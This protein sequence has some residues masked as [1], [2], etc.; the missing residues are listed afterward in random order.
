M[1]KLL[2]TTAFLILFCN[3]TA[4]TQQNGTLTGKVTDRVTGEALPGANIYIEGKTIGATTDVEGIYRLMNVPSG[5]YNVIVQFIGYAKYVEAVEISPG[6]IVEINAALSMDALS[7]EEVYVSAQLLG[8]TKAINQQLN[9]DALVNVVSSDKIKELPDVNAAEAIGRLPG[10]SVIRNGGEA[11]R[12]VVRGLSPNLTTISIN[13]VKVPATGANDRGVDLSMVSPDLLSNIEVFKSP[14]ADMDGDAIGGIVNLGIAKAPDRPTAAFRLY[15]GYNSLEEKFGNYK[16]TMDLSKRFFNNKLGILLRANKEQ[17][18]RSSENISVGYNTDDTTQFLVSNLNIVD[19]VSIIRRTGG[20]IQADYQYGTGYIIGQGFYSRRY[21]EVQTRNNN[22]VNGGAVGHDPRHSKSN[23]YTY[24]GMLNG[25]QNL[26]WIEIDW[27]MAQSKTVGDNY[28]DVSL[29]I[30]ERSGVEQTAEPKTPQELLAKRLFNYGSAWIDRYYWEPSINDQLNRTASVDFKIDYNLGSKLGGFI[31]FGGKYRSEE[32]TREIDYQ[33]QNWYYLQPQARA[34]AVEL[35][36]YDMILGG[37]TGNMIMIDNFYTS[38][39]RL[40]IWNN[41]YFIHPKIDMGLL[42]EWH[43]YQQSTLTKQYSQEYLNYSIDEQVTAGYLMAKINWGK[44]LTLIPGVRYEYSDNSYSGIISSLDNSGTTGSKKDTTTYQTYGELLP[45]FHL[46]IKPLD[47]FDLRMS[48]VKTLARPNYNMITPRAHVDLTNGRVRRGNP[49]LK[50]AEAWNYDA[51]LSF[52]SNKLG[53]LTFGG[54]YKQFN[55]YFTNTQR[56][57][58]EEEARAN[59]Y[60]V[61]VYDVS[62]D[63]VNFDDSKVYGLEFDLQTNFSYLPA[64]FNGFVLSFNA[65]RLWSETYLPLYHK[66]TKWDPAKRR[67]VVDFEKSYWEYLKTSLPDQVKW[68]SNVSLGYDYKGFSSR[69]SMAYQARY[70][71][72]LSSAGEGENVKFDNQYADNFLRFD[73]S[74]SQKIGKHFMLM[75]NLANFTGESERQ[76]Q[77]LPKYPR[78]ENRYGTT[79]DFGIQ[80]K[81]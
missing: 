40:S 42:D 61:S 74:L 6:A 41:E 38:D 37:N 49:D 59:G 76:Y 1:S 43:Y 39:E 27:V 53:L 33:L 73:A 30:S 28:Y 66:V 22:I 12:V 57:M 31:K 14:T 63:Y 48:V 26:P 56:S 13:G 75:A 65:T 32:R 20:N 51:S 3:I 25:R 46:K 72:F 68:I 47:W 79:I 64:P 9:S 36:P 7:L 11:S 2:A 34:K 55:N 8:Q 67:N 23:T 80:Y 19:E 58:P 62:E 71:R 5:S 69:I 18:N 10:I 44:W 70:L 52:F 15:G 60:P 35:W 45:S 17:I 16:G 78:N 24:Q 4:F 29:E 77:Y 81:F 54:F 21:N 50:Y